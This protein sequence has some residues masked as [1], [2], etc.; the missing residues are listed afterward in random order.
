MAAVVL[1]LLLGSAS[2]SLD[3][4]N[5]LD[6]GKQTVPVPAGC[7]DWEHTRDGRLLVV[8]PGELAVP[9]GRLVMS[10]VGARIRAE[11][12][13]GR[14]RDGS[15]FAAF[16]TLDEI[17]AQ[18]ELYRATYPSLVSTSVLGTTFEGRN[19]T[20]VRVAT[21]AGLPIVFVN[22]GL[23]A[24]EWIGP[25]TVMYHLD[26]ILQQI[27][28]HPS[29]AAAKYEW[30][31]V[32]VSN[33]DGYAFTWSS[34]RLWRKNRSVNAA[35]ACLGTD[36]NRNFAWRWGESGSSTN[37]CSDTFQGPAAASEAETRAL[38]QH[39]ASIVSRTV[40]FCDVHSYFTSW[41]SVFGYAAGVYPP[42]YP[43][44]SR[45]M[46]VMQRAVAA[47]NGLQYAVGTDA[48]VISPSSGGSDD[49]AFSLGIVNAFTVELRG[50][51]FVGTTADIPLAGSEFSA[52]ILALAQALGSGAATVPVAMV[53]LLH[54]LLLLL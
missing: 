41:T 52:G 16:R 40:C 2:A 8:C 25:M 21:G 27:A 42:N 51:S 34:D 17:A 7:R 39:M 14:A 12:E 37:P 18:V 20:L 29:T 5:V 36:N 11:R 10:D 49:H 24:R 53:P 22:T 43:A 15:F 31:L 6:L 4:W 44:L 28:A 1:L 3:G 30:H 50:D 9:G 45:A 35:S 32:L 19:I 38:Q 54:L 26:Q 33:P 13:P 46:Q 47:V 48:D 23:H